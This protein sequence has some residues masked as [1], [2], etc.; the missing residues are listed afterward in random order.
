MTRR[1]SRSYE[2]KAIETI[3]EYRTRLIASL[4]L[5]YSAMNP[6]FELLFAGQSYSEVRRQY[7]Q[8]KEELDRQT[9]L[10]LF[11]AIEAQF[12]IDYAIRCEH[13]IKDP[14][15]KAFQ[16]RHKRRGLGV[17]LENEI[18]RDWE[19]Y[20][21]FPK[22]TIRELRQAFKFRHWLAHGRYWL[23]KADVR[24]FDFP[25]LYQLAELKIPTH[26]FS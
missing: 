19:E 24:R 12:R 20:G 11:S 7:D 2:E 6:R 15:S 18:L 14:L 13:R 8:D 17:H 4:S 25:Y 16:N 26:A 23:I 5:Y 10:E 1:L 21:S 22:S 9:S 3:A